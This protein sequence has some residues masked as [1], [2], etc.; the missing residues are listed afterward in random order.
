MNNRLCITGIG[1]VSSIGIG[2]DEFLLSLKNGQSGITE[3]KAFD[4]H[5]SRSK[6][7]GAI[8]SFHPKDF[9]PASK[10]RRLDRASQFAI[11]ASKLALADAQ[12][13]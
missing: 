4:T 13:S 2:K 7:G 11:A 9:I 12:F 5:F 8:R 10:I 1:V 3:I 6:K